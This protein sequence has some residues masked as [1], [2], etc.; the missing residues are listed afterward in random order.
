[1]FFIKPI[2]ATIFPTSLSSATKSSSVCKLPSARELICSETL[3]I[4]S[5]SS[6][7]ENRIVRILSITSQTKP[8]RNANAHTIWAVKNIIL[9]VSRRFCIF[10]I[11]MSVNSL[12]FW[13]VLRYSL[14]NTNVIADSVSPWATAA[15]ASCSKG[16][17]PLERAAISFI[18]SHSSLRILFASNPAHAISLFLSVSNS[19]IY[20]S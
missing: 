7:R 19:F 8:I 13:I 12:I 11:V 10:S 1:M 15:I 6:L 4:G 14:P 3:I 17:R 5:N 18:E 2:E 20:A 16:T 9:E